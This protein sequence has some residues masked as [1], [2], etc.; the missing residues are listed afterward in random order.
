MAYLLIHRRNS[1]EFR[2]QQSKKLLEECEQSRNE[3]IQWLKSQ[4]ESAEA[5]ENALIQEARRKQLEEVS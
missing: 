3:Q 5:K 1:E 4:Q 2:L